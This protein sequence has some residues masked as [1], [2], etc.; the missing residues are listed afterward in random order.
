MH[1]ACPFL[2]N[3]DMSWAQLQAMCLVSAAAWA[4]ALCAQPAEE[5]YCS[6]ECGLALNSEQANIAIKPIP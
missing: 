3:K 2:G 4:R 5:L 1:I 6:L